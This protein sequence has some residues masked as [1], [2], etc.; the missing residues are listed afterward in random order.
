[1]SGKTFIAMTTRIVIL[2]FFGVVVWE[3]NNEPPPL[4]LVS[5]TCVPLYDSGLECCK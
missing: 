5:P 4:P 3:L 2:L 1:M